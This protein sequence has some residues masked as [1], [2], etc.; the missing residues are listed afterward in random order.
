[1]KGNLATLHPAPEIEAFNEEAHT[2]ELNA[3]I[4]KGDNNSS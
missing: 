3:I 2:R 4:V 1:M